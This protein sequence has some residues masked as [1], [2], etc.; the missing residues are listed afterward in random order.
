MA[1]AAARRP[2][3]PPRSVIV[4][5]GGEPITTPLPHALPDP[6]QV[7]AADSGLHAAA[8]LGVEVDRIVGDLDSVDRDELERARARGAVVDRHPVDKDRTDLAIALDTALALG[9]DDVTVVGG[10]GGRLDHLLAGVMLLAAPTYAR[11]SIRAL[12]GP[13]VVTVVRGTATLTGREGEL[14]SLLPVH[15]TA[16][17][18]VTRGLRFPL[19]DEELP[20]GSSRGVSNVLTAPPAEVSLRDGVLLAVQPGELAPEALTGPSNTHATPDEGVEP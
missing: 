12:M 2:T 17:G 19:D 9:A 14:V 13:A 16:R 5:A 15:G 8:R 4:L 6:A 20:S 11:A 3:D 10:D 7:I 1:P 18:V